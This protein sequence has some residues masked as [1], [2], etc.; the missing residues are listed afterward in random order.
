[1][2]SPL[3][4]AQVLLFRNQPELALKLLRDSLGV[5]LPDYQEARIEPGDL[6]EIVAVEHR[7]DLIIALRV[8][9]RP[10]LGVVLEVQTE[11]DKAKKYSWPVYRA[12]V[13]QRMQCPACVM[14]V[15]H[16]ESV[17][18]WARKTIRLGPDGGKL[19]PYVISPSMVPV[20][21]D[22]KRAALDPELALLSV[23]A[24][25]SKEPPERT[26]AVAKAV[27]KGARR[28]DSQREKDYLD[29]VI[30]T[31]SE[32]V[33][34]LFEEL[35]A[36]QSEFARKY[37]AEGEARGRAEGEIQSLLMVVSARRI[38][39]TSKQKKR[40]ETCTNL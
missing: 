31:V 33:R 19:R 25:Q 39:L 14:V 2:P 9:D 24:H 11:R 13:R 8:E 4:E 20:V 10:V 28:V 26:A 5:A 17:A 6:N 38:A 16:R 36:Y 7:A 3:H 15:T 22:V 21:R 12:L 29:A 40:I 32:A 34:P 18:R 23:I 27:V 30:S 37:V 1:M 35:M